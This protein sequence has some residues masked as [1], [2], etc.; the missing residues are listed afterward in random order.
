MTEHK[1]IK[2]NKKTHGT[3]PIWECL[4]LIGSSQ[5]KHVTQEP[6]WDV[7]IKLSHWTGT[8]N[9]HCLSQIY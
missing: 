9:W 5:G 8:A 1:Y 4:L 3:V 2:Q 7:I 6:I